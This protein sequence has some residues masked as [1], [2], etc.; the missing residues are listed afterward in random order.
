MDS[1]HS[2][3]HIVRLTSQ[4]ARFKEVVARLANGQQHIL[5]HGLPTAL[6]AFLASHIRTALER[7]VLIVAADEDRAEQWRDDLQIIAGE[8]MVHYFPAWDVGIYD[9]QSPDPEIISLRVATAARLMRGE[10]AIVV[11]P[12]SA[13]LDPL[14]PPHALELGTEVLKV[15]EERDLDALC[16]HWVACGFDR[17]A[18]IDGIGQFSLRGGILD[19]Y[20]F[21]VEHPYRCEFF[22]DEIESIRHFDVSTQRSLSTCEEA[23]VLPAREVLLDSPF[24]EDYLQRIEAASAA[25]AVAPLKDQLELGESLDGIE[26]YIRPALRPRRRAF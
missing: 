2:L 20:P 26:S 23:W 7:P 21:G 1:A 15:G 5:F 10:P 22:G 9:R 16:S 19:I 18:A 13:L 17:V 12:A 6:A 8:Q 25:E 14:I 3:D 24:Y 11:A 4:T